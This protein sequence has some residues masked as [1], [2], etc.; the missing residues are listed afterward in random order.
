MPSSL[1]ACQTGWEQ[2]GAKM[3][4]AQKELVKGSVLAVIFIARVL[5]TQ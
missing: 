4:A 3:D 2:I 5:R 1:Q